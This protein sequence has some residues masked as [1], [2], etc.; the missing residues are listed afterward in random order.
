MDKSQAWSKIATPAKSAWKRSTETTTNTLDTLSP[1]FAPF[2]QWWDEE[3]GRRA[4][5][6]GR[7]RP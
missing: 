4:P 5:V 2:A 6:C 1:A 7:R 3:A